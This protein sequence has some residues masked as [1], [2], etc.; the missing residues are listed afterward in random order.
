VVV[1]KKFLAD[2]GALDFTCWAFFAGAL[3]LAVV[4]W[5]G[6][7]GEVG[8]ASAR[9]RWEVVY[10]GVFPGALAYL[11]FAYAVRRMK[12]SAVTSFMNFAPVIAM[13]I[14][15]PYLH[16]VPTALSIAG[17]ALAIGGVLI[18]NQWGRV[19][20]P[21]KAAKAESVEE[22]DGAPV[23]VRDAAEKN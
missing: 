18:V 21:A 15:W 23:L 10:L 12:A 8:R 20:E 2:Y 22:V 7:I 16:E 1:H 17:G 14:A 11:M 6:F 9:A 5:P 3:E 19:P 4:F 13:A